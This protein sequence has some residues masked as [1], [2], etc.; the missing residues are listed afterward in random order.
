MVKEYPYLG[1]VKQALSCSKT[2]NLN[3]TRSYYTSSK[4]EDSL[5][6]SMD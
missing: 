1:K 2:D 4:L 6:K 3:K 5:F